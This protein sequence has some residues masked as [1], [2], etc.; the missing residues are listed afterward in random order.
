[1]LP[2][3]RLLA[4]CS[5]KRF[6]ASLFPPD[7]RMRRWIDALRVHDALVG[8]ASIT[9]ITAELF[10]AE[11][12]DLDTRRGSA[13]LKSRTRRLIREARSMAAG[14]YRLLMRRGQSGAWA[15][16]WGE[17]SPP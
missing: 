17:L 11:L 4:L 2:L 5:H 10:G 3:R 15:N 7:P 14:G 6:I 8:G 9:T 12:L 1:M 13:S 16:R